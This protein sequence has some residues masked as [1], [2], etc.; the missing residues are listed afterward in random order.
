MTTIFLLFLLG[1][2]FK[3]YSILQ[4]DYFN[5]LDDKS[6]YVALLAF[7]VPLMIFILLMSAYLKKITLDPMQ[8]TISFKN[9]I[10]RQT[11][12]YDLESFDGFID[13][14]LNHRSIS[15]K[16]VAFIK[17][18]KMSRYIDS[19]WVSNYDEIRQSIQDIPFLG[20][21]NFSTWNRIKLLLKK[22]IV[23]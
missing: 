20:T 22:Q 4:I 18:K 2:I 8:K 10:T 23:N 16:T 9:L 1:L 21:Y 15:Y 11:K 5:K 14:F 6:F 19:F 12:T 7:G 3:H 17:N 13:T